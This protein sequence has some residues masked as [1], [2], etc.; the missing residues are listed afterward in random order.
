MKFNNAQHFKI[1]GYKWKQFN[2]EN[3][4]LV[5]K[6]LSTRTF[7]FWLLLS[8]ELLTFSSNLI[9]LE[10]FHCEVHIPELPD[11][12]SFVEHC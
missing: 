11:G 12:S 1:T 8:H 7:Q 2:T 10:N 6:L 4:R 3:Q 5:H 9:F